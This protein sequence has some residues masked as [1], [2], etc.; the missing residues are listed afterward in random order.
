MVGWPPIR[1]HWRNCFAGRMRE[2]EGAGLYVKVRMDG[3]PYMRKVDLNAYGDYKDLCQA[4]K[5]LFPGPVEE[6]CGEE[7]REKAK[8]EIE[9]ITYED[10]DGEWMLAGDIP[11]E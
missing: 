7:D 9:V 1:A 2:S 4:L 5:G 8:T 6:I 11:W 10:K 3:A